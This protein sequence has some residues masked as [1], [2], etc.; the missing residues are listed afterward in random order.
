M[1][2]AVRGPSL[3]EEIPYLRRMARLVTGGNAADADDLVQE[4]LLKAMTRIDGYRGDASLRTWLTAIMMNLHK[5]EQRRA[6]TRARYAEA[7]PRDEPAMPARQET[8]VEVVETLEALRGLPEDQRMALA[9]VV[10]GEMSY[11]EGAEA[12]GLKLGTFMSRVSRGRAAL[13]RRVEG[14]EATQSTDGR[15]EHSEDDNAA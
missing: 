11:A 9:T 5:S 4:T 7:Q 10:G 12:L 13:R 6:A 1:W 14:T 2:N 8:K 3:T 15:D